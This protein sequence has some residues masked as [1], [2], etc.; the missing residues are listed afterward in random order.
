MVSRSLHVW[1]Y[2]SVVSSGVLRMGKLSDRDL[3][4][5][6]RS[7][8]T[9]AFGQLVRRHQARIHRLALH[10]LRDRSEAEPLRDFLDRLGA[11]PQGSASG[12]SSIHLRNHGQFSQLDYVVDEI[13]KARIPHLRM[14]SSRSAVV[15]ARVSP[16][17][18]DCPQPR[19]SNRMLR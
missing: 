1:N 2:G 13:R 9:S 5:R 15:F 18:V 12:D 17:G 8:D 3:V 14:S 16:R 6:A 7:G 11:L 10:M 4:D 19:W